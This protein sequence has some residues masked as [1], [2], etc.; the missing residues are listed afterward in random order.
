MLRIGTL[1]LAVVT[2]WA[3]PFTSE[4]QI[5]TFL[6]KAWLGF[7]PPTRRM[8]LGQPSGQLPNSS[9]EKGQP[10]VSTSSNPLSTLHQ[11]FACARLSQ[12]YLPRSRP[13]FSATLTTIVLNN[14][15]LQRFEA[16]T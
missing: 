8:P 1:A 6:T 16:C 7:A 2:A 9:R 11:R 12:P 10:P 4:R 13:D 3:S 14:S 5:L 15:S